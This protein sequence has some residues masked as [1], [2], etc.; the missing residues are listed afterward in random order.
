MVEKACRALGTLKEYSYERK[1]L[2]ELLQQP[3]RQGKRA[4]WHERRA[5]LLERYISKDT[6]GLQGEPDVA[7][8]EEARQGLC[9][10]LEDEHT[11]L[12]EFCFSAFC[13]LISLI[14]H[15]NAAFFNS[16]VDED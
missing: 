14:Q 10:A 11:C 4:W 2:E 7:V 8:L 3:Y 15:S 9:R 6:E 16:K 5:L 1:V 13:F 12:G